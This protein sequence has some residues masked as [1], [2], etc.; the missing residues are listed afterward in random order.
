MLKI[1]QL[2]NKLTFGRNNN[3]KLVFRENNGNDEVNRFSISDNGMKYTK[4][5]KK[6]KNKK[7]F[8]SQNLAKLRKKLL[9]SRN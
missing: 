2:P 1:T 9:K 5:F 8:K 3:N 7:L 6:F 4:K